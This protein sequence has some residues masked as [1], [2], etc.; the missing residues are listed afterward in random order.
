MGTPHLETCAR[1][2]G[3]QYVVVEHSTW[4]SRE[5]RSNRGASAFPSTPA[6]D[7][8]VASAENDSSGTSRPVRAPHA[9]TRMAIERAASAAWLRGLTNEWYGKCGDT[10]QLQVRVDA[11]V[12]LWTRPPPPP[13]PDPTKLFAAWP[14]APAAVA[15][16]QLNPAPKPPVPPF[17]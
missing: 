8:E 5:L 7:S 10:P 13:P 17:S 15:A 12:T 2:F 14:I 4:T 6:F 1:S 9:T 11:P 3:S 16:A